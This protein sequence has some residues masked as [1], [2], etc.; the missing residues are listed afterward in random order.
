VKPGDVKP[1][2]PEPI[3]DYTVEVD[4][5]VV[6]VVYHFEGEPPNSHRVYAAPPEPPEGER[7]K[8]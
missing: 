7:P 2:P 1:E 8:G 6:E 4:G 3:I 5:R